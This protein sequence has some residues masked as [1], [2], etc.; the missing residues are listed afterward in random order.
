MMD[1]FRKKAMKCKLLVCLSRQKSLSWNFKG[2]FRYTVFGGNLPEIT[3]HYL[4]LY[5][6][7]TEIY[8]SNGSLRIIHCD[9][10]F[11][12]GVN[13]ELFKLQTYIQVYESLWLTH[14]KRT[15]K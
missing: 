12:E 13:W 10:R 15:G 8:Q 14:K 2:S 1:F 6:V 5:V 3:Q 11:S 9:L 4:S 7:A